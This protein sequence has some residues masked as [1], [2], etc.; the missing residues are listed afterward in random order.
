MSSQPNKQISNP[1]IE[2]SLTDKTGKLTTQWMD[3]FNS[4]K[5]TNENFVTNSSMSVPRVTTAERN[6]INDPQDGMKIYN[7][8]I[9]KYQGYVNGTWM[10]YVMETAP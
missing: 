3:W 8:D 2:Y 1:P 9:N 5:P 7:V 4:V 10:N 6:A